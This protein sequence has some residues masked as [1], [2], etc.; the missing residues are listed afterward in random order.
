MSL[1]GPSWSMC[2]AACSGLMND[3]VPTREPAIVS[4][5]LPTEGGISGRSR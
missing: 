2:P 4:E 1:A 5:D 3:G